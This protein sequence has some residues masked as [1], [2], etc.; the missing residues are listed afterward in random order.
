[1]VSVV[2][3]AVTRSAIIGIVLGFLIVLTAG[4]RHEARGKEAAAE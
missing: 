1:L 2:V 3:T 4:L